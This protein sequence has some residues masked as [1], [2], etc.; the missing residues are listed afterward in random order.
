MSMPVDYAVAIAEQ[1]KADS[2]IVMVDGGLIFGFVLIF[3]G[4]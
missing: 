1:K 4:F 3:N 2:G